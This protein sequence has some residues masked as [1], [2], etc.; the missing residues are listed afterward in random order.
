MSV[1]D[2]HPQHQPPPQMGPQNLGP[3]KPPK[4]FADESSSM[5]GGEGM[6]TTTNVDHHHPNVRTIFSQMVSCYQNCS[7]LLWERC[8]SD[9]ENH[10][11]I[12]WTIYSNGR[13]LNLHLDF[14]TLEKFQVLHTWICFQQTWIISSLDFFQICTINLKKIQVTNWKK[15]IRCTEKEFSCRGTEIL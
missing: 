9:W 11:E 5:S 6:I 7:D 10:F 15:K 3:Q 13:P 14:W 4:E 8:S 2:F 12:T 1:T